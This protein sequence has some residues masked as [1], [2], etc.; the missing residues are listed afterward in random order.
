MSRQGLSWKAKLK[1]VIYEVIKESEN[2][3]DFL[4]KCKAHGIIVD[5]NPTKKSQQQN[6][7]SKK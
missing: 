3:E 4:E 1:Y 5:Y 2:F 7:W 6:L